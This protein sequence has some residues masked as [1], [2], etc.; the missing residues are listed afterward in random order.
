MRLR[1]PRDLGTELEQ[2]GARGVRIVFVFARGE[3]GL[4]LLDLQGGS[5]IK[6]L[7]DS[8]RIH[9][10]E[11]ADHVFSQNAPRREL[12]GILSD[13][14]FARTKWSAAIVGTEAT[15]TP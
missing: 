15:S 7:G 6:R 5:S 13:E 4:E 8:C 14:L 3:P 10:V 2:L 12:C 9:I 1:L 11:S